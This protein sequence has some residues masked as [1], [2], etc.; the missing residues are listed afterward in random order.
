M[1]KQQTLSKHA[2]YHENGKYG[3]LKILDPFFLLPFINHSFVPDIRLQKD[4]KSKNIQ[5]GTC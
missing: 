4:D 5:S 3:Y 1:S 2:E